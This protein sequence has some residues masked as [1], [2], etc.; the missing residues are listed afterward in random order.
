MTTY[1]QSPTTFKELIE[2]LP[3]E[4]QN[5]ALRLQKSIMDSLPEV[6]ENISGGKKM[7]IMLFVGFNL[8]KLCVNYFST[9]GRN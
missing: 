4:I 7:P 5:I 6:D 3:R 8:P 9:A 1:E 2:P